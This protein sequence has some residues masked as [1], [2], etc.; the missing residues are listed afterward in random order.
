MIGK[1]VGHGKSVPRNLSRRNRTAVDLE[2]EPLVW[3]L[4]PHKLFRR[5]VHRGPR[6]AVS[7][8]PAPARGPCFRDAGILPHRRESRCWRTTPA[9]TG[10]SLGPRATLRGAAL[11][12]RTTS[13]TCARCST[14]STSTPSPGP[15]RDRLYA[16]WYRGKMLDRVERVHS[17]PDL[18]RRRRALRGD[19]P[20]LEV[21]R[22]RPSVDAF[23]PFNL[24]LRSR[25]AAHRRLRG[26]RGARR[27]SRRGCARRLA[28]WRCGRSTGGARARRG[29]GARGAA[30]RARRRPRSSGAPIGADAT[31]ALRRRQ[32]GAAA[33][34]AARDSGGVPRAGRRARCGS[35]TS[36]TAGCAPS[37]PPPAASMPPPPRAAVRSRRAGGRCTRW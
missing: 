18:T 35:R 16:R 24:R 15:F 8:G 30:L 28:R 10:S 37:S 9:T 36:R 6:P 21:E 2:W 31:E 7:R 22:M 11:I 23:L 25:F 27:T 17:N 20:S 32:H 29:G 26:A 14:S 4:T 19:A 1:V 34:Q 3:L 33:A 13:G 5:C 12:P